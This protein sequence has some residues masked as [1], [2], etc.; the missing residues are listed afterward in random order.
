MQG[1]VVV[2]TGCRSKQVNIQESHGQIAG[3]EKVR[4][5]ALKALPLLRREGLGK[6]GL[7]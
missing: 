5:W 3:I 4:A 1:G 2:F 6:V 7:M